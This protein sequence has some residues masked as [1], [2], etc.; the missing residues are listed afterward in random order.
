MPSQSSDYG[1]VRERRER[2]VMQV[3]TFACHGAGT[4]VPIPRVAY[5][6]S[7]RHGQE[8]PCIGDHGWEDG[9]GIPELPG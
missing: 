5:R 9:R 6:L 2:I 7:G 3:H 4:E 1:H 8:K